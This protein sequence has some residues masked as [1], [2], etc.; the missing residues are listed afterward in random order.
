[1]AQ[2]NSR[3]C[4]KRDDKWDDKTRGKRGRDKK[5]EVDVDMKNINKGD[6]P[7]VLMKDGQHNNDP[8]WYRN[9]PNLQ[10]DFANI[11]FS[12]PDGLITNPEKQMYNFT[13]SHWVYSNPGIMTIEVAPTIGLSDGPTS[14]A[15]IAAQQM[16]TLVRKAN[17]GAVNYDKTDLFMTILAMDSAYMLYE[18]LLRIYRT[19]GTYNYMNRYMP[20]DLLQAL[21]GSATLG[22]SLADFRGVLDLF[23]YQLASINVPDQ[24][25]IIKRHSWLFTNVYTDAS[26][27]KAQ[28]YAYVP[29]GLYVWTE[30]ESSQPTH[31]KYTKMN[32]LF[33]IGQYDSITTLDQIRKAIDTIMQPILGSQDI[34]II[35]GDVA[36]AFGEGGMIRIAPVADHEALQPVYDKEVLLQMSNTFKGVNT[37]V[38]PDITAVNTNLK[39]GPYIVQDLNDAY[40]SQTVGN[41]KPILN[42]IDIDPTPDNIMVA[43]RLITSGDYSAEGGHVTSIR[44][45]TEVPVAYHIY[46]RDYVD[47]VPSLG[48]VILTENSIVISENLNTAENAL[49]YLNLLAKFDWAPPFYLFYGNGTDRTYKM[50]GNTIDICDYT[51]LEQSNLRDLHDVAVMSLF[52]VKDYNFNT[53]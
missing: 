1:M 41:I 22:K 40:E 14:A 30:G 4:R 45:G 52:T 15:N 20:D 5:V 2:N 17:S 36:K 16:Y 11:P 39:S 34:G 6:I 47:N 48:H 21:G 44:Y 33:G 38:I 50:C 24:F 7:H 18:Y 27:I 10:M 8:S 12:M 43:S 25:D 46:T 53:K 3:N 19:L 37:W 49:V 51:F 23:A 13:P 26:S 42:L 35:S 28:L 29:N 32:E 9:I 31:L